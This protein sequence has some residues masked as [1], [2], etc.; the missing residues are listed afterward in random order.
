MKHHN[1]SHHAHDHGDANA[2]YLKILGILFALTIITVVV[3]AKVGIFHFGV[4]ALAVAMLIASAKALL[5]VL[6]FMHLKYENP[7]TWTYALFPLI[8]L[9]FLMGG[10]FMDNPTRHDASKGTFIEERVLAEKQAKKDKL[11]TFDKAA[12]AKHH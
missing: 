11:A 2:L 1:S 4:W 6:F 9:V 8:L 5:V 10:V 3:S 7:L 12:S